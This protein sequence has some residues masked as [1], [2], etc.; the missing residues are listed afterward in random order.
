MNYLQKAMG[1]GL[2]SLIVLILTIVILSEHVE[3]TFL[4]ILF[5]IFRD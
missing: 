4:N 1:Y 5:S 2:V 3:S